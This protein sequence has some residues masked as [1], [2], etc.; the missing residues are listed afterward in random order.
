MIDYKQISKNINQQK[1]NRR[2]TNKNNAFTC[3]YDEGTGHDNCPHP[4]HCVLNSE[5]QKVYG[6][7]GNYKIEIKKLEEIYEEAINLKREYSYKSYE[8]LIVGFNPRDNRV[9]RSV[10]K[11]SIRECYKIL[12]QLKTRKGGY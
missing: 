10:L 11:K 12:N 5:F 6:E 8:E 3:Y 7:I 9:Q 1:W 4:E 2:N